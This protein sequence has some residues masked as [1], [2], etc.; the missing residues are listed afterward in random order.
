MQYSTPLR[1]LRFILIQRN[2]LDVD[3]VGLHAQMK[4]SGFYQDR[5]IPK[6]RIFGKNSDDFP[7]LHYGYNFQE[8]FITSLPEEILYKRSFLILKNWGEILKVI[9]QDLTPL[10]AP[11]PTRARALRPS[12]HSTSLERR[13]KTGD[14]SLFDVTPLIIYTISEVLSCVNKAVRLF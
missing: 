13:D 1:F 8:Q 4:Q 3:F 12:A 7:S 11:R 9:L 14:G 6:L 10:L 5:K 2:V